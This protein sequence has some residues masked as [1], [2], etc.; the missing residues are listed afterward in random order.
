MILS[1]EK[2]EL[3][4]RLFYSPEYCDTKIVLLHGIKIVNLDQAKDWTKREKFNAYSSH[5]F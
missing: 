3:C 2:T 4:L 5:K 1:N